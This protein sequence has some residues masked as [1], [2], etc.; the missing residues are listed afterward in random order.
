M[1]R[2]LAAGSGSVFQIAKAFRDGESGRH[3]NP[4]FTLLE[5][6]RLGIDH[7]RLMDEIEELLGRLGRFPAA[8]RVAYREAFAEHAHVDPFAAPLPRLR[9]AAAAAGLEGAPASER[10]ACLD[11]LLSHRVVPGLAGA[12]PGR[13]L[14]V[15]GFPPSQA[16]LARVV[17][18]CAER[19]E[20]YLEGV[21]IANGYHELTDPVEQRRRFERLPPAERDV[22]LLAALE[23]G[24]PACAG[25]AMGLDRLLMVLTGAASLEE[26]LAF[27]LARA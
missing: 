17:D 15:H 16:A 12:H 2:L 25:V 7:H 23:H 10:D 4:E 19:F 13:P 9:A 18:G 3:H 20:L 26:V 21:E 11:L 14:F 8:L 6:Y 22:E 24:M 5:W 27:P 1:K